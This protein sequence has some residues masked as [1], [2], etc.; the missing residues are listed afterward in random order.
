MASH[1]TGISGVM[2]WVFK[3]SALYI[4]PG[5]LWTFLS[6]STYTATQKHS[7]YILYHLCVY[8]TNHPIP[9]DMQMHFL[10]QERLE[11]S[12]ERC[13]WIRLYT[14]VVFLKCGF[15]T[16]SY[17]RFSHYLM[18]PNSFSWLLIFVHSGMTLKLKIYFV[19][20]PYP[21]PHDSNNFSLAFW[22]VWVYRVWAYRFNYDNKPLASLP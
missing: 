2:V 4:N 9:I 12:W 18:L 1:V 14:L 16:N 10:I 11:F 5:S 8:T 15:S 17:C 3:M 7:S 22:L 21:A 6:C 20:F 13:P 19:P